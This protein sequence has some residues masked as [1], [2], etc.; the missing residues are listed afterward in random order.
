MSGPS[1]DLI[2]R[3]LEEEGPMTRAE[4]CQATGLGHDYTSAIIS[5]LAR[6]TATLPKRIYVASYVFDAEGKRRY[7]R[8]VYA[9]GDKR[10]A[11]KPKPDRTAVHR[12][13]RERR[14]GLI[15]GASVFTWGLTRRE[16]DAVKKQRCSHG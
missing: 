1:T 14:R 15:A 6:P 4:I 11:R 7:P 8:A 16:V 13:F 12:R 5:R 2:L 9:I 10:D 3:K